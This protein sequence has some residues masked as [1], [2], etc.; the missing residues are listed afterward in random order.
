MEK[1]LGNNNE[2]IGKTP[3][4]I[5]VYEQEDPGQMYKLQQKEFD[6][7]ILEQTPEKDRRYLKNGTLI[8]RMT[9][10]GRFRKGF[11]Q[12]EPIAKRIL[13]ENN[14]LITK[15]GMIK[16]EALVEINYGYRKGNDWI[17][18]IVKVG[19]KFF[20]PKNGENQEKKREMLKKSKN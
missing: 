9:D 1:E 5:P 3:A 18:F 13:N 19:E 7:S 6:N 15:D 11:T 4:G 16:Y 12:G 2:I 10:D 14:K 17:P 20:A 8:Q